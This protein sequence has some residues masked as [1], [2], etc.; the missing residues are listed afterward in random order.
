MR[1]R[2]LLCYFLLWK[3]YLENFYLLSTVH[4][5]NLIDN[6]FSHFYSSKIYP[7]AKENFWPFWD[8]KQVTS[9][10]ML[11]FLRCYSTHSLSSFWVCLLDSHQG[12]VYEHNVQVTHIKFHHGE[13]PLWFRGFWTQL[14]SMRMRVR[15]LALLS[16]LRIWHCHELWCKLQTQLGSWG[17][18]LL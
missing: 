5:S 2:T 6:L 12:S 3:S 10:Q 7:S 9:P 13:F 1:P 8:K 17:P 15:S 14:V 16:G 18:V 4:L 11:P